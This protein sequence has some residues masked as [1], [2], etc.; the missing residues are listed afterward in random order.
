MTHT[1]H[2]TPGDDHVLDDYI[3]LAMPAKGI[4]T[5]ETTQEKFR[6]F[7]RIFIK[8]HATNMGGVKIG[9]LY[10][11]TPD[12]II[13]KVTSDIPMVHG[14]FQNRE[15]LVSA[16]KEIKEVDMGVSIIVTG[17]ASD[18]NCCRKDA[19][20]KRH[21][22][23]YSLGTFGDMTKLPDIKYLE[24]TSMCGH[25]MISFN[26]VKKVIDDI[27]S[28]RMSLDQ[29]ASELS[30]PCECGIFNGERAKRLLK[31]FI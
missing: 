30:K 7:L 4:N 10:N 19:G 14:V 1:L 20:L 18:I 5:D 28:G 25:A 16:L 9:N 31:E 27:K 24:I 6:N 22:I 17:L 11:S 8:H 13:Q 3:I 23:N 21:S 15:D 12:E 29:A 2:R 26:L